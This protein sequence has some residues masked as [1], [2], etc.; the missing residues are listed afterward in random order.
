MEDK[1]SIAEPPILYTDNIVMTTNVNGLILDV[2]QRALGSKN[3]RIL[4]RLGM[5]REHAKKFVIKLSRLLAMTEGNT[6]TRESRG[7]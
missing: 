5:S 1:K 6:Q 2:C 4:V 7:N 3:F